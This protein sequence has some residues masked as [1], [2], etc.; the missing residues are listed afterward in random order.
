M[1]ITAVENCREFAEKSFEIVRPA[2][3]RA[4]QPFRLLKKLD[5]LSNRE[6]FASLREV[7]G[8]II[9]F[10][11]EK[12]SK[13]IVAFSTWHI[14]AMRGPCRKSFAFGYS[15]PSGGHE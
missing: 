9:C 3:R 11:K 6:V 15:Y 4:E 7:V 8:K 14:C 1:T 10:E 5:K 2:E 13:T 12:H